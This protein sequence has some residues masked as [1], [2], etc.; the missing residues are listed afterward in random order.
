MTG[1][2]PEYGRCIISHYHYSSVT[3]VY[4]GRGRL[5]V[6]KDNGW[7]PLMLAPGSRIRKKN[8]PLYP[9][10]ICVYREEN[11]NANQPPSPPNPSTL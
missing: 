1:F 11:F 5:S 10:N 7:T 8:I 6:A 4:N 3:F 2:L 9:T